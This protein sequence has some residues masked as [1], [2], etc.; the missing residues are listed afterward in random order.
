MP[1]AVGRTP[2]PP[3][4]TWGTFVRSH[5]GY[6]RDRLLHRADGGFGVLYVFFVLSLERRRVIHANVTEHPTAE[7]AAQQ[8]VEAV[9]PDVGL[10]RLIRDRDKIFGAA[11][12]RRVDNLG[13]TQFPNR[14]SVPLA[15]RVRGAMGECCA[16]G[17]RRP[18]DRARRAPPSSDS[19]RVRCIL[20]RGS[21]PHVAQRRR[22]N[23]TRSRAALEGP[24]RRD[25]KARWTSSSLPEGRRVNGFCATTAAPRPASWACVISTAFAQSSPT[26]P[27]ARRSP[28]LVARAASPWLRA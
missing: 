20:Q 4:Q 22:A 19:P 16:S 21:P 8:V 14:G 9:G 23:T 25:A 5:R 12:D 1:R 2:R 18:R 17:D 28:P 26:V 7:W 13:L 27:R 15:E 24:R 10:A 6:D 11:F 3:S